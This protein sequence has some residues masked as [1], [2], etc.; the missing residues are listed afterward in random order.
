MQKYGRP[1]EATP[2]KWNTDYKDYNAP[3]DGTAAQAVG[4]TASEDVPSAPAVAPNGTSDRMEVDEAKANGEKEKEKEKEKKR[5]RHEGETPEERVERKRRKTE[6]K[7]KK[8]EKREKKEKK[9]A[10]KSANGE[11]VSESEESD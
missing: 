2:A 3:A 8:K 6:K 5:K 1:N 11:K 4:K 9:A 10:T 7:E